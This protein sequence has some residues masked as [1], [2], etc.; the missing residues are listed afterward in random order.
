MEVAHAQSGSSSG[1][2]PSQIGICKCW[3]LSRGETGVLREKHLGANE[4]INNKRSVFWG[5]SKNGFVITDHTNSLL[6]KNRQ[7]RKRIIYHDNGMSSCSSWKKKNNK[8]DPHS[9]DKKKK[10]HKLVVNE[11]TRCL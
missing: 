3:F 8:T 10:Q 6:P 5:E 7:S 2:I 4:R 9:E 1:L 11:Y